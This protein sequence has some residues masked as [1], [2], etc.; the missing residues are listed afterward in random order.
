MKKIIFSLAALAS[1]GIQAQEYNKWSIDLNGG[2]NKPTIGFTSGYHTKVVSPWRADLGV[3]YMFNNKMGIRL[4]GGYD[5]F[6]NDNPKF[7][8]SLWNVN[9]QAYVNVGRVLSFETW[10][11]D[12]GLLAHGGFGYGQLTSEAFKGA[13]QIGFMVL[14]VTPQLRLS[15]RVA[16]LLDGSAYFNARQNRTFDGL[17]NVAVRRGIDAVN[18]TGTL[19][20]QIALGG[21]DVHADWYAEGNKLKELEERLNKA[22]KDLADTADKVDGKADKMVDANG[23]NIPDEIENYLNS[24][25][26]KDGNNT[27]NTDYRTGDVAR[28][29]IEKGYINVYF[30][31]NSTKPQKYSLWAADFI[32]NY[33]SQNPGSS[34]KVIGYAD[35]IGGENYN[36]KLSN[37]RAEVIRQLLI[38]IG[39]DASKL[40]AEGKG[41]DASVNKNS[42]NAR[43]LARRATFRF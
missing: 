18:F 7:D 42:Q 11:R 25:F 13:D 22:E 43:Q 10:T 4:G 9:L 40:S 21:K 26:G 36:Q 41:E 30:D 1:L 5:S 34:I 8:T 6:S 31:F 16:L 3:R 35:E 15:N 12:L 32:A 27:A 33:L 19:G 29:L 23:N 14:G 17:S 2:L 39:V 24:R 20:L 28:E 38:D 37:K